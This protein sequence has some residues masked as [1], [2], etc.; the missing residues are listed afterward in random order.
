MIKFDPELRPE[1]NISRFVLSTF[2]LLKGLCTLF[3]VTIHLQSAMSDLQ[4]Y[5]LIIL[6]KNYGVLLFSI[7]LVSIPVL[8]KNK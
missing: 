5:P 1:F 3:Q 6:R 2:S 8:Y 7:G 4:R